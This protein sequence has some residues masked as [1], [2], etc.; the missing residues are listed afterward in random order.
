MEKAVVISDLWWK[1]QGTKDWALKGI[2]LEIEKGEFVTIMGPTNAGKT[3]LALCLNGLIDYSIPGEI[4]GKVTVAGINTSENKVSD[5]SKKVGLIFQDP[6]SQFI[7]M[8]VEEDIAFGLINLGIPLDVIRDRTKSVVKL[9][10][11][12]KYLKKPP[13]DL[14]GGE[15]QRAA[16]ASVL[17]MEPEILILDEPDSMIDPIGKQKIF[18]LIRKLKETKDVTVILISHLSEEVCKYSDRVMLLSD[19]KIQLTGTPGQFFSNIDILK[20]NGVFSPQVTEIFQGIGCTSANE[21]PTTLDKGFPPIL[22][23]LQAKNFTGAVIDKNHSARAGKD[24]FLVVDGLSFSYADGTQALAN[25]DLTINSG[26]FVAVV[27]PNGSGKTTL[28]KHFNGLLLPSSGSVVIGGMD[29]RTASIS[30]IATNVGYAFQ[31]PDHQISRFTVEEEVGFG[32]KH[33]G[34]DEKEIARRTDHWIEFFGF[35]DIRKENPFFLSKAQRMNLAVAGTLAMEP[36]MLVVDEPT[37]GMDRKQMHDVLSMLKHLNELGTTVVI[38]THE[39]W[40][41][42]EFAQRVILMSKG[43]KIADG[44]TRQVLSQRDLLKEGSIE[45]TQTAKL[46]QKLADHSIDI[47]AYTVKDFLD[48]VK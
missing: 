9:V 45:L 34:L 13:Q 26:E 8:S 7:S 33:L 3:T 40:L 5:I 6:E 46:C 4:K 41:I 1:Y 48:A 2:N 29:T 16:I 19:G 43:K 24:S 42:A 14:S 17:A 36:H 44:P 15:K 23:Q 22:Q 25:I 32:P 18:A 47:D 30:D 27:G 21:I 12:E 37:T 31:N 38:V 28:C 20:K 39:V 35:G 11:L 10:E